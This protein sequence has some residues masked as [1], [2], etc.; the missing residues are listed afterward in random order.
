MTENSSAR[1]A[2]N[3]GDGSTRNRPARRKARRHRLLM[4]FLS[5]IG[6]AVLIVASTAWLGFRAAALGNELKAAAQLVPRLKAEILQ[7]ATA[8]VRTVDELKGHTSR[9]RG[10]ASDP[11]W[12]VA[13][14]LPW[15]GPNF[16]AAGEMAR[17]AD[18][19]VQLGAAPLI[20]TYQA[21]DWKS[22]APK[23]DGIDLAPL[24]A[25]APV[26]AKAAGA[27]VE[28]SDRLNRI[29]TEHLLP[30]LAGPLGKARDALSALSSN[31]D[32]AADFASL[33]PPMLGAG[34]T[35]NYLLMIQNN[36]EARATGGIP[37]AVALLTVDKGRLTLGM[38]SGPAHIG[39]MS[40]VLAVDA[41]QER[42]YS[43]RLGMYLQD[44][45]LT[46]DFPTA[47]STTQAMWKK[48]TGQLVDG[49]ISVDPVALGYLLDASGPVKIA[50]PAPAALA[51][52]ALP[53]ELSSQ[54]VVP[55]LLSDVYAK[56]RLPEQQD[57]YF[58]EV[59]KGIFGALSSG[60]SD[61]KILTDGLKQGTAEGRILLWSDSPDE[62]AVIAKHSLSGSI[63]GPS[64]AAA[65]FGV[66]FN[67]GTGAKMDYYVKRTVQL[68][69]ECVGK[70]RQVKVR[71]ES[72]NTAPPDAAASLPPYVTGRG[73][74]GVP[75]GTVRTN[76]IAYGP[77]RSNVETASADGVKSS[78]G[79]HRHAHRPVGI[80]T[81]SLAPG[82]SST[83][84]IGFSRIAQDAEPNVVVTPT[85]QA[86]KNVI[87]ATS[88]VSC[89][90]DSQTS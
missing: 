38:Q 19:V 76:V 15:I 8:A 55:T 16:Q 7:D 74:Y 86:V 73:V 49:V 53:A 17:S 54:N 45:N 43:T 2:P 88:A 67:D 3:H 10:V 89:R 35:R 64:I 30:P 50:S 32:A 66:Y 4:A 84:E 11:L 81:V 87:L 13:G 51:G 21:L 25:A 36:A 90:R 34:G 14:F 48:K 78:F 28:S 46:P 24:T 75:A 22:L 23:P 37:G 71:I 29:R 12:T 6:L 72:T 69:E 77:P 31:L 44:V 59:T 83:V 62:Q 65:Q 58:A 18:D 60:K 68:V 1:S 52:G 85:V 33:A 57:A 42:I 47:A 79:A 20:N 40:P 80:V 9:A 56:I 41:E 70:D 39:V 5:I 26:L 63:A 61:A 82:E 27:V